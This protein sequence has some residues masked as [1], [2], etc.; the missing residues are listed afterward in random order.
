[1]HRGA[2]RALGSTDELKAAT[3]DG[4]SLED[5]FRHHTGEAL[6]E[7]EGEKGGLRG[8]RATRRTARRLG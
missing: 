3:G 1:M 7:V 4:A 6:D 2:L 5:V 8:V